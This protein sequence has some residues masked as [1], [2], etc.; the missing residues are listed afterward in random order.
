MNISKEKLFKLLKSGIIF[1]DIPDSFIQW[2]IER[3][4]VLQFHPDDLI[5]EKG[6][7]AEK[8][9]FVISGNVSLFVE[10][11]EEQ[12][13]VNGCQAGNYFGFEILSSHSLRL[14]H[15]KASSDVLV[16][17]I[18][19]RMIQKIDKQIPF[20]QTQF[21]LQLQSL[22]FLIKK[23]MD[24]L[25]DDEVVHYINRE[26]SL[27]LITR[28][29]KP[30]ILMLALLVITGVLFNA[31]VFTLSMMIWVVSILGVMGIGGAIWN[32]FDWMNDFFVIT[33][34]RVV[35]LEKIALIYDSRKETPLSAI[36]SIT[37]QIQV[38]GRFY[39]YGD[40]VLRTFTGLV[41]FSNVAHV[42]A[43]SAI[44][45]EQW[46]NH[47]EKIT[48]EEQ[49]DP[50]EFLRKHMLGENNPEKTTQTKQAEKIA[51]DTLSS[52]YY[53]DFFSRI[54]KLRMVEKETIIYRTHWFVFIRKTILPFLGFTAS[55]I[56]SL[57]PRYGWFGL[58]AE[59]TETYQAILI[60]VGIAMGIWWLY[61][62]VD[63]RNDYF[64][65]TPDQI[66]D[67]NRK[68][69]GME[70]RRSAPIRNI[71]TIEYKRQSIFGLLFNFGTVFI[72][73]GDAEFTFDY[74]PHPSYVQQE[75]YTRFEH[76][77]E[78]EKRQ[79]SDMSN[80]RLAHWMDAYHR[81]NNT[82]E[83]SKD[84]EEEAN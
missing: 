73:V 40:V 13:L 70:E 52:N 79:N 36:L 82:Q 5:Y 35:F 65:I 39:Q 74:V 1:H 47:K 14:T 49:E 46:L 72:R 22:D 27:I 6:A 24:W 60:A 50:E 33:N 80:E 43:V 67:V 56:F 42:E 58:V 84:G 32:V 7:A 20:F 16:L 59:G 83:S 30:I 8:F 55:V 51:E 29:L 81:V 10:E 64:L 17:A 62:T 28:M 68:P 26:H 44:V 69:L 37:R 75:I 61:S 54:L 12:Y 41:K 2:I 34:Q 77:K 48:A 4:Q 31:N 76:L 71:Q 19:L 3:S 66:V 11:G 45:E 78:N 63:W 25:Q 53:P 15:A 21:T 57:A 38:I 18:P 9:F 23:P